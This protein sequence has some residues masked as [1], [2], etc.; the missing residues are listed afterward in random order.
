MAEE[1][2]NESD[3]MEAEADND[4]IN[5]INNLKATTVS[6]DQY[7]KIRAERNRLLDSLVNGET[8]ETPQKETVD[9]D[10]LRQKLFTQDCQLSNLEYI[11]TTLKLRDALMEKGDPDPFLPINSRTSPT[12]EE[13]ML[14][15]KSAQVF[16]ECVEYAN[17]DSEVFTN[18]LMRRTA[19]T[20]LSRFNRTKI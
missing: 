14:A 4:Y 20:G 12:T 11:E 7:E 5:V 19:D 1:L 9:I 13:Q 16:R 15:E 8:I 6:K 17:G 2:L 10:A 3:V 18:E